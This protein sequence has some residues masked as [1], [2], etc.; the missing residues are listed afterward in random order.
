MV[1]WSGLLERLYVFSEEVMVETS[2]KGAK[3]ARELH[4][5]NEHLRFHPRQARCGHDVGVFS[6]VEAVM[7]AIRPLAFPTTMNLT[8]VHSPNVHLPQH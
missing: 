3:P 2:K 6:G 7:R 5:R 4:V 1:L 8:T